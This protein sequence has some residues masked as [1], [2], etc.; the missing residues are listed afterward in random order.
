MDGG[1]T[2]HTLQGIY[3]R[4]CIVVLYIQ[5]SYITSGFGR[6]RATKVMF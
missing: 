2:Y 1:T 6:A 5:L 3:V 4:V